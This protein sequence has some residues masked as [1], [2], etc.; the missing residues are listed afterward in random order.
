MPLKVVS[1]LIDWCEQTMS[2]LDNMDMD[3]ISLIVNIVFVQSNLGGF[4]SCV[5]FWCLFFFLNI[6]SFQLVA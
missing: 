5:F 1:Y 2:G 6:Q 3:S 4:F